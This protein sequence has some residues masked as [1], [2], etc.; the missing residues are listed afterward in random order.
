MDE[1]KAVSQPDEGRGDLLDLLDEEIDRLPRR[2]REAVLLCELE[3]ASRQDAARRLGL[4][5]GTLSSRLARGRTLLRDR[6]TRR[7]VML[8]SGA[9]AALVSEPANAALPGAALA[10]HGPSCFE[11]R[12]RWGGFR[13]SPGSR[14]LAGGRS[15]QDD[16]RG[17]AE[18]HPDHG[19]LPG[20][21]G[22]PDSRTRLGHG[23][24]ARRE[25]AE[26]T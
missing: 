22:L 3:G 2:Y 18:A 14:L 24:K 5:E 26:A 12:G 6:L 1:S 19:S 13:D 4:P 11:I 20:W 16:L 23:S 8:A 9:L 15:T 17:Q 7:G 10:L 25:A 21:R